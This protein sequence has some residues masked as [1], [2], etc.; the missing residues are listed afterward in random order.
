MARKIVKKTLYS[1]NPDEYPDIEVEFEEYGSPAEI[2]EDATEGEVI[3]A[4]KTVPVQVRYAKVGEVVDTRP[5]V[6][7]EGRVY[8]F[9]EVTR[10][11][12]SDTKNG[13]KLVIVTNPDGEEYLQPESKSRSKYQLDGVEIGYEPQTVEPKG[14]VLV[15]FKRITKNV[16]VNVWGDPWYVTAGGC[17][18]NDANDC[19]P[20]TNEAFAKTY[21]QVQEKTKNA[22]K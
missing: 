6:M 20:I 5:R 18:T 13:E 15:G 9:S 22:N 12:E 19:Y 7:Y 11:I 2:L 1:V 3:Y 21:T 16:T 10:K 8:T 4:K 14:N 17:V